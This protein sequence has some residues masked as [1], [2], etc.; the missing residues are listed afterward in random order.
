MDAW[1]PFERFK[2]SENCQ[3][4]LGTIFHFLQ[5]NLIWLILSLQQKIFVKALV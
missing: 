3:Y 2:R 5:M 1:Q 4:S